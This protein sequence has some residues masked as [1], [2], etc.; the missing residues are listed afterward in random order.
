MNPWPRQFQQIGGN[1]WLINPDHKAAWLLGAARETESSVN[2]A[3]RWNT[4]K[5]ETTTKKTMGC[6]E[7]Q[8]V[9]VYDYMHV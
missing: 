5:K 6:F 7:V 2:L 9:E 4:P 8:N 3:A 1:Q